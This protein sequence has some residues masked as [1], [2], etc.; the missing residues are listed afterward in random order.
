MIKAKDMHTTRRRIAH[1]IFQALLLTTIGFFSACNSTSAD[2]EFT[3]S[4]KVFDIFLGDSLEVLPQSM[5]I[6]GEAITEF[7]RGSFEVELLSGEYEVVIVS[8]YHAI[9]KDTINISDPDS[10]L[11]FELKSKR[12]DYFSSKVG[13]KWVYGYSSGY[14][15]PS[16]GR[17]GNTQGEMKW[18]ILRDSVSM[19]TG[20]SVFIIQSTF[21]GRRII[22]N[23]YQPQL[24]DTTILQGTSI[25]T[26]KME[27]DFFFNFSEIEYVG[28]IN[29][30][31][32]YGEY[33]T[34]FS[35]MNRV[36]LQGDIRGSLPRYFPINRVNGTDVKI[37]ARSIGNSGYSILRKGVGIVEQKSSNGGGNFNSGFSLILESFERGD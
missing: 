12:L 36:F 34:E 26:L 14:N 24:S 2:N 27:K 15:D 29:G 5:S 32:L 35:T 30:I 13:S 8:P 22:I 23:E 6:G 7:R 25:V 28:N 10:I 19:T 3:A 4:G 18:E 11:E 31:G 20:D 16:H 33:G 17:S 1:L 37:E 21:N 9:Y